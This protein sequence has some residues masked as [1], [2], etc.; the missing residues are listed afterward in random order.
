MPI[1]EYRCP[2]CNRKTE[3]IT[4]RVS[5]EVRPVCKHCGNEE[6]KRVP[7]RVR[8][9]L[10]EETRL[11]RLADPSRFADLDENDPGSMVKWI[12]SV[13][14]EMG[15]DSGED[16]DVD[17]MMDEAAWEDEAGPA[18]AGPEPDGSDE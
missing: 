16:F 1:Y 9:R 3:V 6:V 13:S 2:K 12:K 11:E 5:E 7:S 14:R 10:S 18:S 8:V 17:A 4:F 15:D